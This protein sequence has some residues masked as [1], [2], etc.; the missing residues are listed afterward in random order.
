L[1]AIATAVITIIALVYGINSEKGFNSL[2]IVQLI[3]FVSFIWSSTKF[4][5]TSLVPGSAQAAQNFIKSSGADPMA[6]LA[7][8]Y[9]RQVA[10]VRQP[11]AI[12][13]DN[14]DRCNQAYGIQLLEGL[15]TIFREVP[16]IYIVAADRK[17]IEKMYETQYSLFSEVIG[18]PA[19][20]FGMIFLDKIFQL[21]IEL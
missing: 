1:M 5:N 20:P 2:S 12:F 18:R 16:V 6:V 17:W 3:A 4:F 8:H 21:I 10:F 11:L 7:E 15:Q 19:K 13:I 14:L 9:K